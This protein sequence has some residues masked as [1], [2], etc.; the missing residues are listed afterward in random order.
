MPVTGE[1]FLQKRMNHLVEGIE[2]RGKKEHRADHPAEMAHGRSG[3]SR[4][5]I[6]VAGR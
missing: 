2:D 6:H 4:R 1:K 3:P 5:G